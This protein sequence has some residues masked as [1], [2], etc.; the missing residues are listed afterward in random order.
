MFSNV[1]L[2]LLTVHFFKRKVEGNGRL[3]FVQPLAYQECVC[4]AWASVSHDVLYIYKYCNYLY[5]YPSACLHVL[6]CA[7]LHCAV[8]PSVSAPGKCKGFR[9]CEVCHRRALA[10]ALAQRWAY[11]CILF[12]L[13]PG[14][15]KVA[16]FQLSAGE[17][18]QPN[19]FFAP[20]STLRGQNL[21]K[22]GGFLL[23]RPV[24]I[25]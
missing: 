25:F 7:V 12:S 4:C 23:S 11:C 13:V 19:L 17:H 10:L 16:L 21:D 14:E 24:Q 1:S 18:R 22:P 5:V 15:V 20:C 2:K 9:M 8:C 3:R 6:C